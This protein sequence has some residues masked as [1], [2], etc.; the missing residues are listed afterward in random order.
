MVLTDE[1]LEELVRD[2]ES[3]RVERKQSLSEKVS[4]TTFSRRREAPG[5]FVFFVSS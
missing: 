3:D 2:I 1:E 4:D 5:P